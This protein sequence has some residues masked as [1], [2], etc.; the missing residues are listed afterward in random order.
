MDLEETE[1]RNVFAKARSKLTNR[2]TETELKASRTV[3]RQI[4]VMGPVGLRTNNECAGES[5]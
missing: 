1:G 5:Q 2:S 3:R 4:M